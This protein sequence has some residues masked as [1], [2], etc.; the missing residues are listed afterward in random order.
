MNKNNILL[1]SLWKRIG[2]LGTRLYILLTILYAKLQ[3]YA[4]EKL[5]FALLNYDYETK[6]TTEKEGRLLLKHL[7]CCACI[8][9]IK[10]GLS[11]LFFF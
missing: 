4:K 9:C 5:G 7:I 2:C 3:N 10:K 8:K 11:S 1:G 6:Q